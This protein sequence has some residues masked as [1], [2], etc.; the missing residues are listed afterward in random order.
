MT[1]VTVVEVPGC[2]AS[3][4]AITHDVM[5]TANQISAAAR[6][7]LPFHSRHCA[8]DHAGAAA[9]CAAPTLS[10]ARLGTPRRRNWRRS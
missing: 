10:F 6:R 2:M 3:S 1:K 8:A 9:S 4:S 5:A 7:A